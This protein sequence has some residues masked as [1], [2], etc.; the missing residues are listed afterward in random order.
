MPTRYLKPGIRDSEA[1]DRLSPLAETLFYRLLVTVDD[2]GRFDGRASMVKAQCF[3]VKDSVTAKK[4]DELLKELTDSGLIVVYVVDG[5]PYMQMQKWDNQPRSK[6]S[7]FPAPADTCIQAYTYVCKPRTLLPVTVTVTGTETKTE[8]ETVT[9]S[10][11]RVDGAFA[12]FWMAYPKKVGKG[13]A[14]K[15]WKSIKVPLSTVGLILDALSWQTESEQWRKSGGQFIPNPTT[16]LN[17]RRWEDE[18]VEDQNQSQISRL[19]AGAI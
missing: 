16:Y 8:T 6:E 4:C 13:S 12:Q 1:I 7:K 15:A 14:E 3:P 18:K 5:K 2:F 11:E 17:Q 9:V 19:M 10:R